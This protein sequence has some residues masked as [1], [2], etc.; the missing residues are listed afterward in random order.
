MLILEHRLGFPTWS[1]T[2]MP[3]AI[4]SNDENIRNLDLDISVELVDGGRMRAE[5][6]LSISARLRPRAVMGLWIDAPV[7]YVHVH[8]LLKRDGLYHSVTSFERQDSRELRYAGLLILRR[9]PKGF[10]VGRHLAVILGASQKSRTLRLTYHLMILQEKDEYYERAFVLD[11]NDA[12]LESGMPEETLASWGEEACDILG[13]TQ[14]PWPY[15]DYPADLGFE[16]E[17]REDWHKAFLI[18]KHL[19]VEQRTVYVR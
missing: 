16:E 7:T 4:E 10:K 14:C 12:T 19:R 8:P 3:G 1:W 11:V 18:A 9:W 17:K 13:I 5:E 15:A 6:Y 2:S